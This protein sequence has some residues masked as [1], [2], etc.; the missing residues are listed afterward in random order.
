MDENDVKRVEVQLDRL[1]GWVRAS[2]TRIAF[3]VPLATA[4]LG[5]LAVNLP[6][7]QQWTIPAS[8]SVSFSLI[9]L[10]LSLVFV[11]FASF[12]RTKGPKG[13]VVYFGGIAARELDQYKASVREISKEQYVEDLLNQ[14][15]RNAQIAEQKY[16]WIQRS[17]LCLFVATPSWIIA[18]IVFYARSNSNGT[19]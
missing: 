7:V 12:P 2:E 13:S 5:G 4:M 18:L 1:I 11:A 17:M 8:L 14:C 15:H 19:S 3:I 6:T 10:A 9:P 16:A